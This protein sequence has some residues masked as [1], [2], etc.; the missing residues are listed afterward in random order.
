M[1]ENQS[2]ERIVAGRVLVL[3]TNANVRRAEGCTRI[4]NARASNARE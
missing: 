4:A 1:L 3:K 2:E